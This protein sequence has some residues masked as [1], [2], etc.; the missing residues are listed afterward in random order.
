MRRRALLTLDEARILYEAGRHGL[1]IVA[2]PA[3][4]LRVYPSAPGFKRGLL[5]LP[6]RSPIGAAFRITEGFL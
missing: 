1:R 3:Q 2:A 6:N 5:L 4:A